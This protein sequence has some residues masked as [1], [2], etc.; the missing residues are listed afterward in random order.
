MGTSA[1]AGILDPYG[2]L[3]VVVDRDSKFRHHVRCDEMPFVVPGLRV[4]EPVPWHQIPFVIAS[5]ER[6][7]AEWVRTRNDPEALEPLPIKLYLIRCRPTTNKRATNLD[8][9]VMG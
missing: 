9:V 8:A 2:G 3:R 6:H 7:I 1:V 4:R 5:V